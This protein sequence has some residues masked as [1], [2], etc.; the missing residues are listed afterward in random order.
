LAL[1]LVGA[2]AAR[3]AGPRRVAEVAWCAQAPVH[4]KASRGADADRLAGANLTH[5]ARAAIA[6]ARASAKADKKISR[7]GNAFAMVA[8]DVPGAVRI[9]STTAVGI[10]PV[11]VDAAA[12]A[13]TSGAV[14]IGAARVRARVAR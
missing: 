11:G 3:P 9:R 6:V 8:V 7:G 5:L 4:R 13:D 10:T 12:A 1:A 14:R 2:I